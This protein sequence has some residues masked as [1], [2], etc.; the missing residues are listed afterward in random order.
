MDGTKEAT[1][2][3]NPERDIVG[4]CSVG[5]EASLKILVDPAGTRILSTV[6]AKHGE[7]PCHLKG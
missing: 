4:R 1:D 6:T 7:N 2:T 5:A 3:L